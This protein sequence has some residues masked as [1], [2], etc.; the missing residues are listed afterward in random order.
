MARRDGRFA[1]CVSTVVGLAVPLTVRCDAPQSQRW[2]RRPHQP[3]HQRQH[4]LNQLKTRCGVCVRCGLPRQSRDR[5]SQPKSLF[6]FLDPLFNSPH[7][8]IW[9]R[10]TLLLTGMGVSA[11][12]A[13]SLSCWSP[14]W[15]L[16]IR[17]PRALPPA[18]FPRSHILDTGC[19]SNGLSCSSTSWCQS[20]VS[21]L[22]TCYAGTCVDNRHGWGE[23]TRSIIISL[24][25]A[26][27]TCTPSAPASA[28]PFKWPRSWTCLA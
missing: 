15:F 12:C 3:L 16:N 18:P 11:Y 21:S 4:P 10:A 5:R 2:P 17:T 24:S 6:A 19:G 7:F 14:T 9:K 26:V 13:I 27:T 1:H 28:P 20:H 23:F 8:P 22:S 25:L